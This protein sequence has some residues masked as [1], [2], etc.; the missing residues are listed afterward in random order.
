MNRKLIII[1]VV[2]FLI[3][4]IAL[5]QSLWLDEGTTA[6]VVGEFSYLGIV[7]R[8]SPTDFHPPL[9][10]LVEKLW[11]SVFGTSEIAL[12]MPSVIFSLLTGWVVYLLGGIWTAVFFLFNPLIIYYSQEA[13]MY[14]M[15]TCLLTA[16]VYYFTKIL[17]INGLTNLLLFTFFSVLS[18]YTF[19]G[20]I[21]LIVPL[22][23]FL[24]YKKQYR[25]FI[26]SGLIFGVSLIVVS[27]LLIRQLA[28]SREALKIVVNWKQALGTANLKNLL[29]IPLK[30]AFGRI[31][32]YPKWLY[33]GLA[34]IWTIFIWLSILKNGLK[35]R[36][37]LFLIF[38][39]LAIGMLFS[40]FSPLLQYFRFLFLVPLMVLLI[41]NKNTIYR[42]VALA[43][44]VVLSLIYL[45][46]PQFYR[47][48]WK[49]LAK[50]LPANEPIYAIPSSMDA[51]F[52]YRNVH[53]NDLRKINQAANGKLVVIPYTAD[54]Y[55]LDYK[56]SL[57]DQG[58]K[59][60]KTV[61]FRGVQMEQWSKL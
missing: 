58:Y 2:A 19:Y 28:N 8:F 45:L 21:F 16:A 17:R 59:L 35:H 55:G 29:L 54:I 9:F 10:Y 40:L 14:M 49:S 47:E 31:S 36:L 44:F 48:D 46:F 37:Y 39:S 25:V 38:G 20:S 24:F 34:G 22:Y 26:I 18:F 53:I 42:Y 52:Y 43:G 56:K 27:P 30:F 7:T 11:T 33:W 5:N 60:N 3:R 57:I 13:R 61:N 23:L 41:D 15:V 1:L 4:L 51:L 50:R 6:K 12:R 32:F